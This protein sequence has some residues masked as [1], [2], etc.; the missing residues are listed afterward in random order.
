MVEEPT[1]PRISVVNKFIALAG[2]G[3][4]ERGLDR[5]KCAV[6]RSRRETDRRIREFFEPPLAWIGGQSHTFPHLVGGGSKNSVGLGG[7]SA[8]VNSS[9]VLP[10]CEQG[11]ALT[12]RLNDL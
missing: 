2:N 6:L 5:Q 4:R 7:L 11:H 10:G 1:R 12:K 8:R 3:L 9:Q